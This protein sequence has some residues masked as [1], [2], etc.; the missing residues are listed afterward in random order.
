MNICERL[1][2]KYHHSFIY[3]GNGIEMEFNPLGKIIYKDMFNENK[4]GFWFSID[5]NNKLIRCGCNRNILEKI[6]SFIKVKNEYKV[7]FN[8][9]SHFGDIGFH[10]MKCY[11]QDFKRI[12]THNLI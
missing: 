3:Y 9:S 6:K 1:D 10:T 2:N 4:P 11:K 8:E 12:V 7:Y 5:K